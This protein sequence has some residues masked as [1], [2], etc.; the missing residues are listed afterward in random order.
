MAVELHANCC[1]NQ[2]WSFSVFPRWGGVRILAEDSISQWPLQ[3]LVGL[4]SP[5]S[6]L[7]MKGQLGISTKGLWIDWSRGTRIVGGHAQLDVSQLSSHLSTLRPM[8]SYRLSVQG[9]AAPVISLETLEG[10]LRLS[11]SGQ[12]NA[13]GLRFEGLATVAPE[14]EAVLA[15]VLEIVGRREGTKS[16][17]KIGNML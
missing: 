13:E 1:M 6:T 14:Q 8:G 16:I 2:P 15:R 10:A 9:G 17:I 5:W 4:G 3:L 11:G 7:N 12:W